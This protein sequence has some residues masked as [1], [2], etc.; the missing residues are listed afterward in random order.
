MILDD[1]RSCDQAAFARRLATERS[2]DLAVALLQPD[3]P[4]LPNCY[5]VLQLNRLLQPFCS[6]LQDTDFPDACH[7]VLQTGAKANP[8]RRARKGR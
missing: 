4:A 1:G 6:Q 3:V 8:S 5:P 2:L 7:A